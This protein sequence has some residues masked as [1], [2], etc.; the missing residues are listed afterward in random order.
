M[1]RQSVL[2]AIGAVL[3]SGC[4]AYAPTVEPAPA[5]A[6]VELLLSTEAQI[7]LRDRVGIDQ[8]AIRG[9]LVQSDASS[10]MI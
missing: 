7:R 2:A 6:S 1:K 9:N 5:N 8:R 4:Y 10:M 3:L